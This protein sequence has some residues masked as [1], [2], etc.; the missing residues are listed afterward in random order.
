VRALRRLRGDEAV[1][2]TL[3]L[4]PSDLGEALRYQT[5]VTGGWYP[6]E[7]FC[8]LQ[9]AAQRATG[10]GEELARIIAR[11]AVQD[12][13]RGVYRLITLTLSPQLMFKLAPRIVG[14]YYD[15]GL[16]VVDDAGRGVARGRFLG[17]AGFDHN[18]WQDMIGGTSGIMELAGAK[19]LIAR[20]LNG[21]KDGD[22][23]MSLEMTWTP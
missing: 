14:L 22:I 12:D 3:D 6:V 2:A 16:C 5:L 4:L 9:A 8:K 11:D 18:I 19:N 15:T 7:W 17:F 1:A 20:I 23:D 10:E 13:F 21:G